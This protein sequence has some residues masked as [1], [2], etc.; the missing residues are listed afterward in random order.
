M[1]ELLNKEYGPFNGWT[2]AGIIIAGVGLGVAIRFAINRNTP[3]DEIPTASSEKT[4]PEFMPAGS[5]QYNEGQIV[6]NLNRRFDDRFSALWA[7]IRDGSEGE[8]DRGSTDPGDG[9]STGYFGWDRQNNPETRTGIRG[10][11]SADF[12]EFRRARDRNPDP[13]GQPTRTQFGVTG[14][15]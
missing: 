9:S 13:N 5:T 6:E 12:D 8:P 3:A 7:A 14:R 1:R 10:T 11:P 2:W 4:V 15:Y